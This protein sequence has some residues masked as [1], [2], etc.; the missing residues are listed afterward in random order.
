MMGV[1]GLFPIFFLPFTQDYYDTNK[2]YLL[3]AGSGIL[4]GLWGVRI[5][6]TRT[7]TIS[8]GMTTKAIGLLGLA[9]L[10]SLLVRSP[11]KVEALLS[12]FGVGTLLAITL[13]T[14]IGDTVVN[15]KTKHLLQQVISASVSIAGLIAIYQFFG[16]GKFVL[17]NSPFVQNP[18][19]TPV[20]ASVGLVTMLAV[21]I[22]LVLAEIGTHH[23]AGH[24]TPMVIGVVMGIACAIGMALTIYQAW[25]LW[26]TTTIPFWASWPILLESYKY[27][28]QTLFGV[29]VENF[30]AAFTQGRPILLN[31]TPLWSTRFTSSSSMLFHIATVYGTLGLAAFLYFLK[32]LMFPDKKAGQLPSMWVRIS[33]M[34]AA[35]SLILLPPSF[36]AFLMIVV[37]LWTTQP[38]RLFHWSLSQANLAIIPG[39]IILVVAGV[40][41]YGLVRTYMAENSFARS[42]A[43]LDA[44]DGTGAYNLQIDAISKNPAISRYHMVYSQTNIALASNLVNTATDS[45]TQLATELIQQAIREAKLAVNLAPNNIVAWE[46]LADIYQTLTGAT[47]G[48]DQ[49]TIASYQQAL[50]LDPTNPVLRLRLGG[51]Y[52]AMQQFDRA[53]DSYIASISLKQDYANAYY[54]LSF[55]YKQQKQFLLAAQVLNETQKYVTPGSDDATRIEKEIAGIRELLTEKEKLVLDAPDASNNNVPLSPLP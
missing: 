34:A 36:P 52:V 19:W 20:G 24:D 12:P 43:K 25:P 50:Q 1:L 38:P 23:R 29:G 39:I 4:L 47:K 31:T 33:L 45:A 18:L 14:L 21:T 16:L 8:L 40:F 48:A 35:L 9:S 7:I 46:N 15:E 44:R 51:A 30:L 53:R 28:P 41:S 55:V 32:H 42:L 6:M 10:A 27:A 13:F 17:P 2:W 3:T 5:M 11:N 49:W 37:I 54:N 26:S 22:P